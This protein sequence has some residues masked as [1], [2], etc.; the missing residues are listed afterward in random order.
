[1][2]VDLNALPD[3]IVVL[4]RMVHELVERLDAER[5]AKAKLERQVAW[6][7]RQQFGAKSERVPEEQ[8]RLWLEALEEDAAACG[9]ELEAPKGA[10][11]VSAPPRRPVRKPLPEHLAREEQ[12][13]DLDAAACEECGGAL[14]AIG[15]EVSEQLDY[16]PASFFVRRTVRPKYACRGCETVKTAPLPPAPIDKGAAGPGLLAHVLV[17]K[18]ADHQPLYRQSQMFARHEVELARNTLCGWVGRSVNHLRPIVEHMRETD[19]LSSDRLH[20]DD[21]V[22]PVLEPGRGSTRK[23]RLWVYLRPEGPDPPAVVYEYTPSRAHAGPQRFLAS[24]EGYLQADAFPG[25]EALYRTGKVHEVGCWMHARRNFHELARQGNAPLAAEALRFIAGLYEIEEAVRGAEPEDR[26]A[27]R[28]EHARPLLDEL[29]GWLDTHSRRLS[30]KSELAQAIRYLH[31]RW[32][33]FTRYLDDGRLEL[34]NGAAER[35]FKG[36][37]LGRKNWMFAGSDAGAERAAVVFSLIETCKLNAIEPFAYLRDVL[38]RLPTH[39]ARR[40]DELVPYRWKQC[41][42]FED[43]A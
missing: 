19:V 23:G 39:P 31:R 20:T 40:I 7:S 25:Y 6:L 12:I 37:I 3:D 33:A 18:Y 26:R 8:L 10:S 42:A 22:V 14:A 16:R 24:F 2:R 17:S 21:T 1:M 29:E 5:E 11:D 13:L 36:P 43:A 4:H 27:Y 15:E 38:A 35:A 28:E 34:D 9:V 30:R 32:P 41:R